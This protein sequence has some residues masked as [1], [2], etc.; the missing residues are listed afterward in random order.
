[1]ISPTKEEKLCRLPELINMLSVSNNV[2]EELIRRIVDK[3]DNIH[4][5]P[6]IEES[7]NVLNSA[8]SG[9]DIL[10]ALDAFCFEAERLQSQ[11]IILAYIQTALSEII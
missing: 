1:M 8:K 5:R 3:V 9:K 11:N 2:Q 4:T 10:C 7:E 6:R